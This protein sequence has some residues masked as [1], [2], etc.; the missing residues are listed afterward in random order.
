MPPISSSFNKKHK[1]LGLL[2]LTFRFY[3]YLNCHFIPPSHTFDFLCSKWFIFF[4]LPAC[5]CLSPCSCEYLPWGLNR[6]SLMQ[7]STENPRAKFFPLKIF[8]ITSLRKIGC[9]PSLLCHCPLHCT[10]RLYIFIFTSNSSSGLYVPV[11]KRPYHSQCHRS[12]IT[13]KVIIT[14]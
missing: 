5:K 4:S 14:R 1:F 11:R 9:F 12:K 13:G 2:M 6:F 7:W 10:N 8:L 3:L